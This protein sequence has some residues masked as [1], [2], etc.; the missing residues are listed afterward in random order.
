MHVIGLLFYILAQTS[1]T[2][3]FSSKL[4]QSV[5]CSYTEVPRKT[6]QRKW[7]EMACQSI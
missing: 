5:S 2:T 6:L 7:N 4:S 3:V 1:S